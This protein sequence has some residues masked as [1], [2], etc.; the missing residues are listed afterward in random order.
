MF[1]LDNLGYHKVVNGKNIVVT[2]KERRTAINECRKMFNLKW[3]DLPKEVDAQ[4]ETLQRVYAIA[5]NKEYRR[6]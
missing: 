3:S 2:G 5:N 6:F 1:V 4:V